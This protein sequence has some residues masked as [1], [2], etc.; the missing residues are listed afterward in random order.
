MRA[1]TYTTDNL[2]K[3]MASR[4]FRRSR[5]REYADSGRLAS[6]SLD[7]WSDLFCL[8]RCRVAQKGEPKNRA[9][10]NVLVRHI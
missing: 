9:M 1:W 5:R 4:H 6:M 7:V 10:L 3:E 8:W 2:G